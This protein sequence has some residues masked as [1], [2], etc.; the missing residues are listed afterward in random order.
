MFKKIA[1]RS[2]FI[3]IVA[4]AINLGTHAEKA[5]AF[6]GFLTTW[7]TDNPGVSA[8][9]QITIPTNSDFT[10]NYSVNWGD[11][12]TDTGLTGNATHTYA[13]P[14]TYSVIIIGTF[15]AIYF[16]DGSGTD[17]E[18]LL[19]IEQWG[20]GHW[21]S[22][23]A[24]FAGCTNMVDNASDAPDL[25]GV[26]NTAY[27]FLN[28]A[29]FNTDINDWDVSTV[30]TMY[31]MFQSATTFDQPLDQWDVSSVG[32]M[33][34]MFNNAQAFNQDITGW[35]TTNATNMSWMFASALTFNQDISFWTTTSV[36]D[37]SH[38][39][40]NAQA[41]NQDLSVWDTSNVTNMAG[42]FSQ[43]H[44]N[45]DIDSWDTSSVADM[46]VMFYHDTDF[47]TSI[48]SWDV[49]HV[50]NMHSMFEG[51]SSFNS[52][53]GWGSATSHV[54][55]MQGMFK[56]AVL[57]N[58][59]ISG[60][61][62]S[63]VTDMSFMFASTAFAAD[64]STWITS[65]VTNMAAM[66]YNDAVFNHDIG[67]WDT[68]AVTSMNQMFNG[69]SSFN[70]DLSS[71][72]V[73]HVTDM[74]AMFLNAAVFD[75]PLVWGSATS[76]V[77]NMAW[78][79]ANTPFNQDISGWD[80]GSVTAM[81]SMFAGNASFNQPI[82]SWDTSHVT[83]FST[84]FGSAASFDQGIS[85][86]DTSSATN[87]G[88]VFSG[89]T[90][91]DQDISGWDI[92]HVTNMT[93]MFLGDTLSLLHYNKLLFAW[94]REFVQSNVTFDGGN[95]TYCRIESRGAL[96]SNHGWTITDGGVD[97][98]CPS[99][100]L[101]AVTPIPATVAGTE[102]T[103]HF[104]ASVGI[105]AAIADDTGGY[106]V[107]ETTCQN[108]CT[109]IIDPVNHTL[110]VQGLT[111]GDH[112]DFHF[113]FTD[114]N[115]L[116]VGPFS[117]SGRSSSNGGG[118]IHYGCTDPKATNYEVFAASKPALCAYSTAMVVQTNSA[119]SVAVNASFIFT[120]V[121]HYGMKENDVLE[122]QRK[123]NALGFPVAT[124]GA[125]APGSETNYFGQKTRTAV[126][127]FQRAH[128]LPQVGIVGPLTRALLN[129]K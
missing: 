5:H 60:W 7:Q 24:A 81:N 33:S 93:D 20:S 119:P 109:V 114:A 113:T 15:P 34:Y 115:S 47:D 38:M 11:S 45:Q 100:T 44:F 80:T 90:S 94:S 6:A 83:D 43:S 116:E 95:S 101:T 56:D 58:Q 91:F 99:M 48:S 53:L 4:F 40:D 79:F 120:H 25:S 88:G 66:F 87:M 106:S 125:G 35:Q 75:S 85:D 96:A 77:A 51:A 59:D 73:S 112:L 61:D 9:N 110:T 49:S 26:N 122:L 23:Y 92:S 107:E 36:A 42:M 46:S 121:L 41:F 14:G 111:S 65:S 31:G 108:N 104:V 82:G 78:M 39:F 12:N 22:M 102:A 54:T 17:A 68:S 52:A 62:T 32:D 76:H 74:Y 86:W 123:L 63:S 128:S 19:S 89:A 118:G 1:L 55:N 105:D 2:F 71:W 126:M 8:S 28:D 10:Y 72:N 27:M 16:N 124:S 21:L 13:T 84:M 129:A 30:D 3:L 97:G 117:V 69:A 18:K 64:I 103:Y 29:N 67:T 50:T 98:G 57:F 37:M 70:Q 127:A